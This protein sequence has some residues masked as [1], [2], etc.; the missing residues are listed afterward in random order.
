MPPTKRQLAASLLV[1]SHIADREV[2]SGFLADDAT[3]LS[4][5]PFRQTSVGAQLHIWTGHTFEFRSSRTEV[6][7][8]PCLLKALG[9]LPGDEPLI[10]EILQAGPYRA[11]VYHRGDGCQIVGS[12]LHAR[13]GI[14]LPVMPKTLR[15]RRT[16]ST[17]L[18]QLDLFMISMPSSGPS[19]GDAH[20]TAS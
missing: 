1:C 6:L 15:R 20:H 3:Q 17:S 18:A 13:P 5:N 8:L 19:L 14:A 9:G 2:I 12:V 10:Q 7:G 16:K 11:Y 4:V